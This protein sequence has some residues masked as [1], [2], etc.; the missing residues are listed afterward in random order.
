MWL[1]VILAGLVALSACSTTQGSV[2][3]SPTKESF[4]ASI[5]SA[6]QVRAQYGQNYLVD[7]FLSQGGSFLGASNDFIVVR[8]ALASP[9][10]GEFSL[11][12]A[13]AVDAKGN[14]FAGYLSAL[15][16]ENLAAEASSAD[17]GGASTLQAK[18]Q[19]YYL[20]SEDFQ[21]KPGRHS[22]LVILAGR[23]PLPDGLTAHIVAVFDGTVKVFDL[24][25]PDA[26]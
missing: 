2:G 12:S 20:L 3:S 4:T 5:L 15:R 21:V 6:D 7:P 17:I 11:E 22:Y 10:G 16:L 19:W 18:I 26:D 14:T 8:I 9:S 1:P 23:H 25:I 13:S 24:P